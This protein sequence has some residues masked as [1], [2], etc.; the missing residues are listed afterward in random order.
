MPPFGVV[1]HSR[2]NW[3]AG[4]WNQVI[5]SDES[6]FNLSSDDNHVHVWKSHG[7]RLNPAFALQRHTAPTA[8]VMACGATAYNT[9][10]PLVLIRCYITAHQYIYDILQPHVLPLM[11]WL[12]GDIFKQD[13]ARSYTVRVSQDCLDTVTTLPS[14]ARSSN[15]SPIE[16]I[17]ES[18]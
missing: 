1:S 10:L 15:I 18:F 9:Q 14:P 3:T 8:D 12:L 2:G 4:E 7:E 13:N 6:R 16:H 5:F 11:Q 17:W